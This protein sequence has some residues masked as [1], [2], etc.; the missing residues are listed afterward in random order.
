MKSSSLAFALVCA[1]LLA[2]AVAFADPSVAD[3][4][5]AKL[6]YREGKELRDKQDLAGALA[7]FNAA[8][9]L[10]PTPITALELARTHLAMGHVLAARELLLGVDRMPKK[11]DESE[12]AGEARAEAVDLAE[13]AK[14]KLASIR[15]TAPVG[16]SATV[17]IDG[18]E[19]VPAA[20][21]APRVVDPGHH[22]VAVSAPGRAGRVE[23]DL[24]AG[25]SRT[26]VVPLVAEAAPPFVSVKDR[27][28]GNTL[29]W[30]GLGVGALGL[31]V[32]TVTG[33]VALVKS[34]SVK[35]EC[36]RGQCPPSAHADLNL[37]NAMSTTSTIAFALGVVGAGVGILSFLSDKSTSPAAAPP[38]ALNLSVGPGTISLRGAW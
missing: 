33:I 26:L 6:A 4:E 38:R 5:S 2:P 32:G 11:P 1:A 7:R 23:V 14:S 37:T 17:A 20:A 21:Y 19:L 8:Y 27:I 15:V 16:D 3:V 9:A 31:A 12:K 35:S 25:E 29:T 13:T 22:V 36:P 30:V 10:V 34:G 28:T 24:A 18:V